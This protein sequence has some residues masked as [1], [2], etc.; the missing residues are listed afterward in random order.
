MTTDDS[1]ELIKILINEWGDQFSTNPELASISDKTVRDGLIDGSKSIM[2]D[3]LEAVDRPC[4]EIVIEDREIIPDCWDYLENVKKEKK[5]IYLD[6]NVISKIATDPELSVTKDKMFK[7]KDSGF[8][9]IYSQ[10]LIQEASDIVPEDSLIL[11]S[12][13]ENIQKILILIKQLCGNFLIDPIEKTINL[14]SPIELFNTINGS[15][16]INIH[17]KLMK[18][19]QSF[20]TDVSVAKFRQDFNCLPKNINNCKDHKE[21]TEFINNKILQVRAGN[22]LFPTSIIDLDSWINFNTT[23]VKSN[24]QNVHGNDEY[25][26]FTGKAMMFEFFGYQAQKKFLFKSGLIADGIHGYI[27]T[28][29]DKFVCDDNKL[30]KSLRDGTGIGVNQTEILTIPEFMNKY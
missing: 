9:F 29:V 17:S 19:Y 5:I 20:I 21:A 13:N 27:S 3:L 4:E 24:M 28:L 11:K 18:S 22:A 6:H 12:N 7:L 2:K 10:T 8:L 30:V 23:I 16:C 26:Y 14:R 25:H 15:S 1:K